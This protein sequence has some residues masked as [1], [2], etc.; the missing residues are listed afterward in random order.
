[1]TDQCKNCELR[2]NIKGCLETECSNHENWYA[3]EQQILIDNLRDKL[4][5]LK[6]FVEFSKEQLDLPDGY[7]ELVDKK[8]WDLL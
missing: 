7:S 3:I 1:M 2:G 6:P 5:C 8:F 4:R